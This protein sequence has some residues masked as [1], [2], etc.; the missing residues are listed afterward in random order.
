MFRKARPSS[1]LMLLQSVSSSGV[2]GS[3]CG[4]KPVA[5]TPPPSRDLLDAGS[6][7]GLGVNRGQSDVSSSC[8]GLWNFFH[9]NYSILSY[10]HRKSCVIEKN[11]IFIS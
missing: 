1:E 4:L 10:L 6:G 11:I 2:G 8:V 5:T 9:H 3:P 7:G